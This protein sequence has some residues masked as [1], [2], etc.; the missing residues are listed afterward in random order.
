M[1][2]TISIRAIEYVLPDRRVTL[3][4]LERNG[5]LDTPA[6]TLRALGFDTVR[7][8]DEPAEALAGR[9][10]ARLIE[11]ANV[12]REAIGA[13]FHAGALPSSHAVAGTG[14]G[15]IEGFHYPVARLQYEAGLVHAEAIGISQ[16]GCAGLMTA[17]RLA[18]SVLR[19][20]P[21]V[22]AAICSSADVLPPG[23]GRE[24]IYNVI[25]D[26]AC[27]VLV[28]RGGPRNRVLALRQITKGYYWDAASLKN[29]IVAAY[30]P[31]A[32]HIVLETLAAAGLS[33]ADVDWILPHNV[34]LRSW[35]I[36]LRLLDLPRERLFA[37]NIADKGHVIA[38]DNFIN[39][40]DA[41]ACGLLHPGQRLLLFTFGFGANWTCAVIEH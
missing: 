29:E 14:R 17:V 27:A 34:S 32:R 23:A 31:T 35:E 5:Q 30:F 13:I 6:G 1:T 10:V 21:D 37:P 39:L 36:L 41:T 9:A 22:R 3:E 40:K 38:A 16:V 26:G 24:F 20:R 2:D 25:S 28:E 33:P 12:D 11:S 18:G 19:S 7:V 15:V 8:S 4:D